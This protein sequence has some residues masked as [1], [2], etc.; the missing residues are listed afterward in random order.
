VPNV[1]QHID[2]R[3]KAMRMCSMIVVDSNVER[4]GI[5]NWSFIDVS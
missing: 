5:N 1:V 2:H 3:I 4:E